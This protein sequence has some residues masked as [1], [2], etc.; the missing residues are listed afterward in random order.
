MRMA[1]VV[2]AAGKSSRMGRNKLLLMVEGRTMLGRL[3]DALAES[4]VDEVIVVT[5]YRPEEIEGIAQGHGARIAHNPEHEKGMTT[6]FQAGLRDASADAAF[7]LLGDQIGLEPELLRE[8]ALVLE[9]DAEALIV[10]PIFEGKRGHPVLFRGA[11]F[12][13]I[14]GLGE[15][16]TMKD[17]VDRHGGS[18]RL[19]EGSVW[20]VLDI[21]TPEEYEE[22]LRLWRA[23]RA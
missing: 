21:D 9:Q 16:E 11:L 19:V 7:L 13:E 4:D 12:P 5:G 23:S 20:C 22:A 18:H 14:L 10:S 3:L 1:A 15:E 2:L 17:V 8:M 6:S